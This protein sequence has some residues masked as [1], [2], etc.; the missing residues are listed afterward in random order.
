M[1]RLDPSITNWFASNVPSRECFIARRL[2]VR[3][4][5][6]YDRHAFVEQ[7]APVT[8]VTAIYRR[9]SDDAL[10]GRERPLHFYFESMSRLAH[11]GAPWVIYTDPDHVDEVEDFARTLPVPAEVVARALDLVP[12]FAQ[13]QSLREAQGVRIQPYRDRCHV[14]CFAKMGWLAAEAAAPRFGSEFVYWIDAGLAHDGLFPRRLRQRPEETFNAAVLWSLQRHPHLTLLAHPLL[15]TR[16]HD[17]DIVEMTRVAALAAPPSRH[18]I[19][20]LFG[21]RRDRVLE[22]AVEFEALHASLLDRGLLGTEENVLTLIAARHP[23][24]TVIGFDTWYHEDTD[25][26]QPAPGQVPFHLPFECWARPL[27]APSCIEPGTA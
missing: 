5:P 6:H 11:L 2:A 14:L 21:G 4:P 8:V 24:R 22:L 25:F 9:R 1:G 20:G 7:Q 17:V 13:I 12:R 15:G 23:E 10:G 19:G 18:V 26:T 27:G 3:A 16:Q